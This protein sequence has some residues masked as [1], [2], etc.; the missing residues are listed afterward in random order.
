MS[1][2]LERAGDVE[3]AMTQTLR[4]TTPLLLAGLLALTGLVACGDDSSG[5][6]AGGGAPDGGGPTLVLRMEMGGG[7]LPPDAALRSLPALSVYSDGLV[8]TPAP[9]IEIYPPPAVPGLVASHLSEDALADL[10]ADARDS[11]VFEVED[12]GQP[13]VADAGTTVFTLTEDGETR[14]SEVYALGE[15]FEG[16]GLS[17]DQREARRKAFAL[18]ERLGEIPGSGDE[19][20]WEPDRVAVFV[21]GPAEAEEPPL[22]EPPPD[23][24]TIQE[25]G[26]GEADW[27]AGLAG[28]A[29][30]GD[31]YDVWPGPC[32]VFEGPDSDTVLA[33]A[34]QT[35]TLTAW[36]SGDASYRIGIRP[37]LPDETT[38]QD[39]VFVLGD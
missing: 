14:R 34:R 5:V 22:D 33:A 38:C 11:G 24:P 27:P 32:R 4:R 9:M 18:E 37:L 2:N 26:G 20:L 1:G 12:F 8:L 6:D 7:F 35:N 13:S 28:L 3:T 36:K 23:E 16:D 15:G 10:L 30:F 25:P 29:S 17:A 21:F 19:E 39:A 31:E